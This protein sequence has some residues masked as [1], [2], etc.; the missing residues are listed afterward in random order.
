MSEQ[1]EPK[2]EMGFPLFTRPQELANILHISPKTLAEYR[3]NGK[4]PDYIAV[5]KRCVLYPA[6]AVE[7]WLASQQR[8]STSGNAIAA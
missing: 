1:P 4:G 5:S 8:Q 7:S 3:L 6:A 2:S